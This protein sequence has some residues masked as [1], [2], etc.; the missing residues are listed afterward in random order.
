M[1]RGERGEHRLQRLAAERAGR[2]LLRPGGGGGQVVLHPRSQH[3]VDG[4]VAL[5]LVGNILREGHRGLGIGAGPEGKHGADRFGAVLGVGNS[6]REI[7]RGLGINR[8]P[9]RQQGVDELPAPSFLGDASGQRHRARHVLRLH[10]GDEF[11]NFLTDHVLVLVGQRRLQAG[12]DFGEGK[13]HHRFFIGHGD[14]HGGRSSRQRAHDFWFLPVRRCSGD[15]CR[16]GHRR[17]GAEKTAINQRARHE[18]D[19]SQEDRE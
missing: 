10:G 3:G 16:C 11:G 4:F 9:R 18:A 6:L 15:R 7:Q 14:R 1:L 13:F 19:R 17:G 5:L 12:F 8:R 2:E